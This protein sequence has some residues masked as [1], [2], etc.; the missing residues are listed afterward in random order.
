MGTFRRVI[1]AVDRSENSFRAVELV[2]SLAGERDLEVTLVHVVQPVFQTVGAYGHVDGA[3]LLS[4]QEEYGRTVL[5]DAQGILD[6]AGVK[7]QTRLIV[8]NRGEEIC[9]LAKE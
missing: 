9:R 3:S 5:N 6:A 1:V 2:R 7:A 8:G 4:V